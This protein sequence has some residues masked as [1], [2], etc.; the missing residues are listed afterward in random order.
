MRADSD[1]SYPFQ[2]TDQCNPRN[3][4]TTSPLLRIRFEHLK[5]VT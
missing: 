1:V 3:L 4:E 2:I 5:N